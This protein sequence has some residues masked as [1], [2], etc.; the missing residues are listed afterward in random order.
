LIS[1]TG[2][3]FRKN[4]EMEFRRNNSAINFEVGTRA[5]DGFGGSSGMA[6]AIR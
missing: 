6:S 2:D 3:A 1:S 5:F 4:M